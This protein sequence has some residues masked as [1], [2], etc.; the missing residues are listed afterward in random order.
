MLNQ[1]F[2]GG[3]REEIIENIHLFLATTANNIRQGS[4]RIE[5]FVIFKVC[6]THLLV[7]LFLNRA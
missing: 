4:V 3:N 5:K 6:Y 7:F 1:L 2:S